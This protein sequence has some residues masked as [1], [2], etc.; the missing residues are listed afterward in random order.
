MNDEELHSFLDRPLAATIATINEDGTPHTVPTW[1]RY[2]GA[3]FTIGTDASRRWVQ[4]LQQRPEVS[5]VIAEHGP[6]LA[7]VVVRGRATV[8]IDAPDTDDE[9]RRISRRYMPTADVEDY[10][11][12]LTERR[13]LVRITPSNLQSWGNVAD[14]TI[15][16]REFEAA[17][18]DL[19]P[20]LVDRGYEVIDMSRTG[21]ALWV[22]GDAELTDF[23]AELQAHGIHFTYSPSG[24]S[25]TGNRK[26][27]Y[28][29]Y[30][31]QGR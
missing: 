9:V 29:F 15:P 6:P 25:C 20:F 23:F 24:R 1:Y 12:S 14:S 8:S 19:V 7:A 18:S 22:I 2:D 21:G 26:A 28:S 10:M 11:A 13:A 30:A 3:A 5:A 4:N 17:A 31:E 27:W 16:D